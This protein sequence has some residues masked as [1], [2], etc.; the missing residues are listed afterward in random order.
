MWVAERETLPEPGPDD[1]LDPRRR[2]PSFAK[3]LLERE[4][5]PWD[6][7]DGSPSEREGRSAVSLAW[8]LAREP[9]PED[10][11][12]PPGTGSRPG[13]LDLL[14]GRESLPQDPAAPTES[15]VSVFGLLFA[16]EPLARDRDVPTLRGTSLF[17]LLFSR[18]PLE[19][20]ED[21]PGSRRPS[22]LSFLLARERLEQDEPGDNR[23]SRSH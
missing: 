8:L 12:R 13:M 4:Q 17:S 11:P 1:E 14:F 10:E 9:L 6:A 19:R 15:R 22:F 21:V 18:E 7:P 20:D 23:A 3:R 2:V 16:P 5:L